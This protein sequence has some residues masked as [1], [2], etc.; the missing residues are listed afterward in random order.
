MS[1]PQQAA[2]AKQPQWKSR[3]EYDAFNAM[4]TEKDPNKRI[5]LAEAFLQKY[6]SSDFKDSAYVVEMQTYVQLNQNDKAVEAAHINCKRIGLENP[7]LKDQV[8]F[9]AR[10]PRKTDIPLIPARIARGNPRI[11][12]SV[13]GKIANAIDHASDI[14][15]FRL[16]YRGLRPELFAPRC[17][18][19]IRSRNNKWTCTITNGNPEI[20]LIIS[21]LEVFWTEIER[22]DINVI[23]DNGNVGTLP[24][25]R[26]IFGY[27]DRL[28]AT[29]T[30]DAIVVG[31][32]AVGGDP[33]IGP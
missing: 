21:E 31:V 25:V 30:A 17:E 13:K 11:G 27:H 9:P 4:A 6:A 16:I 29:Q 3:E 26:V 19:S 2:E 7:T 28:I 20:L 1:A 24:L 33:V 5:S 14:A 15:N 32:A 22:V 18:I 12:F 10:F 8:E 23:A